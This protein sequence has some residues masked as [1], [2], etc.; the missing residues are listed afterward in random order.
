MAQFKINLLTSVAMNSYDI[1]KS[2]EADQNKIPNQQE[3]K[4]MK[5]TVVKYLETPI[6]EFYDQLEVEQSKQKYNMYNSGWKNRKHSYCY[7]FDERVSFHEN[8]QKELNF[9]M[10]RN[11]W[12]D[13]ELTT[14]PFVSKIKNGSQILL[15]DIIMNI[16][17]L[18]KILN[19]L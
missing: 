7:T 3:I 4:K 6:S 12:L 14:N 13:N 18:L 16:C 8:G 19:I 2:I 17:L 10:M 11:I 15:I 9:S 5:Q 1:I